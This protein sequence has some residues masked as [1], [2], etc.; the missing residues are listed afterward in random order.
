M[1]CALRVFTQQR[2]PAQHMQHGGFHYHTSSISYS[3]ALTFL[4]QSSDDRA[5]P[6]TSSSTPAMKSPRDGSVPSA[7]EMLPHIPKEYNSR[8]QRD[9]QQ[10]VT[11]ETL[12]VSLACFPSSNPSSQVP[13]DN[14]AVM[15]D[16]VRCVTVGALIISACVSMLYLYK[17]IVIVP[18][19]FGNWQSRFERW[20]WLTLC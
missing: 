5:F 19:K 8:C 1:Y 3:T 7:Q 12:S 15:S 17:N 11:H 4:D 6:L 9:I 20:S 13:V 2:L 16:V 14:E 10:D 18:A